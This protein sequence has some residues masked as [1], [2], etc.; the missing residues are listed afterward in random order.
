[1]RLHLLPLFALPLFIACA[2]PAEGDGAETAE[3]SEEELSTACEL[4]STCPSSLKL[5]SAIDWGTKPP[6]RFRSDVSVDGIT[7][8]VVRQLTSRRLTA[9]GDT[10]LELR[11]FEVDDIVLF[12]VLDASSGARIDAA[13]A[14]TPATAAKVTVGG[15]ATKR[16]GAS[17]FVF[18]AGSIDLGGILP[19]ERAFRLRVSALDYGG[20]ARVSDVIADVAQASST[21]LLAGNPEGT[22]AFD[23]D[24][25]IVVSVNGAEVHRSTTPG[26][27]KAPVSFSARVGDDLTVSLFD[28]YGGCLRNSDVWLSGP[29]ISP[30]RVVWATAQRCGT[31]ASTTA[32]FAQTDLAIGDD[33]PPPPAVVATDRTQSVL[34]NNTSPLAKD[35]TASLD[36]WTVKQRY[37]MNYGFAFF[38][39]LVYGFNLEAPTHGPFANETNHFNITPLTEVSR[40]WLDGIVAW[41]QPK[42]DSLRAKVDAD[43]AAGLITTADHQKKIAV[44]NGLQ[45]IIDGSMKPLRATF[46]RYPEVAKIKLDLR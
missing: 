6:A 33:G 44:L 22:A 7:P 16:L 31:T 35:F 25:D 46:D 42:I 17:A 10:T 26:A 12:E 34:K 30:T 38:K 4:G 36:K 1:M 39:M 29:G 8:R 23:V 37:D 21:F 19:R 43:H 32:P 11:G 45:T 9:K 24:D 41:W 13:Y 2:A 40:E 18:A 20:A 5:L 3:A 27:S 14:G 28:T 15:A